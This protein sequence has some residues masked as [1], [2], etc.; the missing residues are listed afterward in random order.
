MMMGMPV[1]VIMMVIMP[2][3]MVMMVIM[4]MIMMMPVVMFIRGLFFFAVHGHPHMGACDAAFYSRLCFCPYAWQS[5]GI[6]P[7]QESLFV[8]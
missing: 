4:F 7:V 3:V 6:H 2:V 5:Q 8:R 1:I